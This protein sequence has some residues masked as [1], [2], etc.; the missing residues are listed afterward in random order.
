MAP[1]QEEKP[2]AETASAQVENFTVVTT[3]E[4]KEKS[5]FETL[6]RKSLKQ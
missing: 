5:K 3:S 6:K 1:T 2:T 4:Q